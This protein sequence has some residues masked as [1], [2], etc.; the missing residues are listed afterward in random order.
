MAIFHRRNRA[1]R[2]KKQ[3]LKRWDEGNNAKKKAKSSRQSLIV[4]C[5]GGGGGGMWGDGRVDGG[6]WRLGI[7]RIC[8]YGGDA[9]LAFVSSPPPPPPSTLCLRGAR[10]SRRRGGCHQQCRDTGMEHK[11]AVALSPPSLHPSSLSSRKTGNHLM[12]LS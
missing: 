7:G 8:R 4:F 6:C 3:R 12:H 1:S 11:V 10:S 5:Q 9:L 2:H